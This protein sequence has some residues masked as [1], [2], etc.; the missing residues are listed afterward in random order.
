MR[1]ALTLQYCKEPQGVL[2][3]VLRG[4]ADYAGS[5]LLRSSLKGAE[6]QHL[7]VDMSQVTLCDAS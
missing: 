6:G 4:E 3:V 1:G 5:R 7:V 2:R